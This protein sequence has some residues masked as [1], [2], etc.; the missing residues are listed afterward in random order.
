MT[1]VGATSTAS[2]G[3]GPAAPGAAASDAGRA[4]REASGR[5]LWGA[6]LALAAAVVAADQLTKAW[7]TSFLAPGDS[8]DIV[9]DLIR[10]VHGQ[11]AGGLFGVFQ[12]QALPF[13]LISV[14]VVGLIV[15]FHARSGRNPY[16]STTLGLLLGG[17]LGN[18]TDRIRLGYVVDFVDAGLGTTR[19]YTFNVADAAISVAILL[20]LAA[21]VWPSVA[22][23]GAGD[24]S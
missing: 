10:L 24:R 20:L 19:W 5:P 21:S 6:F 13:A 4:G 12:G 9:G 14:V 2:S 8:V 16:L 15:L 11:N 22:R 23:R 17:A 18:L 1:E 7:L 3:T